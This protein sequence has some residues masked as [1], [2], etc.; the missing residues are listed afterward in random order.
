MLK[1]NIP[2]Y[3]NLERKITPGTCTMKCMIAY[4]KIYGIIGIINYSIA[5]LCIVFILSDVF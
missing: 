1:I 2:I 4:N 3:F 5:F